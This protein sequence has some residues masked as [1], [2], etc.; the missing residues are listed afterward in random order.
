VSTLE[1]LALTAPGGLSRV[2]VWMDAQRGQV[3]AQIFDVHAERT[4]AQPLVPPVS[5][6]PAEA[7]GQHRGL[8]TDTQFVGDGAVR[9][10]ETIAEAV[11][12]AAWI[13]ADVPPLASSIAR[14]A[15]REP[16]RAVLPHA[17]VPLYVRRPDAELARDRST[18]Q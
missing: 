1:A 6:T 15:G 14:L 10:R 4:V 3:F 13:A 5:V 8:L 17:V 18:V 2:A 7:L 12:D 9:Y 11:R 16:G